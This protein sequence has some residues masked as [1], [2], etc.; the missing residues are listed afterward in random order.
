MISPAAIMQV[1]K[2]LY[3]HTDDNHTVNGISLEGQDRVVV[4]WT[5]RSID[6]SVSY[7]YRFNNSIGTSI[8]IY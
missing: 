3:Q 8:Y 4:F 1:M 6:I 7:Y 2:D 5:R